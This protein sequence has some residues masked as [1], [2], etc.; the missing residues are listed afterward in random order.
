MSKRTSL[1]ALRCA[2]FLLLIG[3][4]FRRTSVG[5]R[6]GER[7]ADTSVANADGER[8]SDRVRV[9]Q[10]HL[11][12]RASRW[13]GAP[14]DQ[15]PGPDLESPL[16]ARREVDR[17]QRRIRRQHRRLRRAGRRRRAEASDLASRRRHGSGMDARRQGRAV[18]FRARDL[19]AERRAA[20]L[21]CAGRGRRR[22]TDGAAARLSGQD[23]ARRLA[24]RLPDEQFVGRGAAQ[25]SRRAEPPDLDRR[26]E[27]LRP[28]VAA[29][30]GLEGR[31]SGVGGRRGLLPLGSRRRRRTSGR[32]TRRRRSWR[33][34]RSS[35]I[36]TS[37]R[38]TPA[39]ARWSSSRP[40]TSTNSIQSRANRASS[41][42][43][44]RAISRG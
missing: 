42:S 25:L 1:A 16:L 21:D 35:P 17:V 11:G 36:S 32:T 23:F 22:R 5:N 3:F 24:H 27:E 44:P 31:R 30:D 40:V 41:T 7:R 26:S 15:L 18:R 2:V 38:S 9:R 34:S 13:P 6:N 37:S 20:L 14:P 39:R 8:H 28:G 12:R 33:R 29:V 19:G 43:R 4:M 10:Q